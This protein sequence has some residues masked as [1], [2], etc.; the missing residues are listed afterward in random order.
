MSDAAALEREAEAARARLSDTAEQIR[1]RMSP[2]QLMDEVLN[3]FRGGDGS[4]MLANLQSQARDNPMALALVGSGLAWLM[5]GSGSSPMPTGSRTTSYRETNETFRSYQDED[6]AAGFGTAA[7]YEDSGA[8]A[9]GGT[10][11][12]GYASTGSAASGSGY[13]SSGHTSS[14]HTAGDHTSGGHGSMAE[15]A[16]DALASARDAIGEGLHHAG[17][18]TQR[19]AHDMR[20]AGHDA[21]GQVRHSAADMSHQAREGFLDI[22]EREPLVIGAIGVAVGAAI[23]AF[24]P[25]TEVERQHLGSAGA[26]L[27]EKA[28][29]LVEQGM[30]KAKEAAAEVY[31]TARD[32]ADRQGLL[33]GDKPVSEKVD[34]VVR[35][36]GE[37]VGG[38]AERTAPGSSAPGSASTGASGSTGTSSSGSSST[39]GSS[40]TGLSAASG[41]TGGSGSDLGGTGK[42]SGLASGT[43]STS[44]NASGTGAGTG[45]GIGTISDTS[46]DLASGLVSD[47]GTGTGSGKGKG[48]GS[49]D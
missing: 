16:A 40:P 44:G 24:L 34:A 23:G 26:A 37:T 21:F 20:A 18:R 22:L 14:A 39:A 19:L 35:A 32:E 6:G 2:G 49:S 46:E 38:I 7:R 5:M 11:E 29:T 42:T 45:P 10:G 41:T 43:G 3:Q 25:A 8:Y 27:K 4:Q 15:G 9:T 12:A 31:E 13:T 1:A 30:A 48:Q 47:T 17:D 28:D 36:V 33:P